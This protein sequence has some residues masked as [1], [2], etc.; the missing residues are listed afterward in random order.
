MFCQALLHLWQTLRGRA[1]LHE[2]VE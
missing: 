2:T 1:P